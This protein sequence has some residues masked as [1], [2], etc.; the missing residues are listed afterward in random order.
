MTTPATA[1]RQNVTLPHIPELYNPDFLNVLLPKQPE[2]MSIEVDTTPKPTNPMI[3]ALQ[4]TAH[5]VLTTNSAAAYDST[6]SPTLDAFQK[7]NGESGDS[8]ARCLSNSWKE[9]PGLT[10]RI[11]WNLRSIPD[12]KGDKKA[13]YRCESIFMSG[14]RLR[15]THHL[16]V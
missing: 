6:L 11:I 2:K 5:Q 4:A 7:V 10:L 3:A 1:S 16:D 9:D 12:G 8:L 15:F 14:L 13:F